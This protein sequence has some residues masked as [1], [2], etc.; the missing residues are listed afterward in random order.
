MMRCTVQRSSSSQWINVV[1]SFTLKSSTIKDTFILKVWNAKNKSVVFFTPCQNV[2]YHSKYCSDIV[3]V[4]CFGDWMV[5]K[6]PCRGFAFGQN[7]A[8]KKIMQQPTP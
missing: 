5:V 2:F 4:C 3:F 6:L 1:S 8:Q 7:V